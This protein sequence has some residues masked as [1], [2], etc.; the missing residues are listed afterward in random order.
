MERGAEEA[1][2]RLTPRPRHQALQDIGAGTA[3]DEYRE[4]IRRPWHGP[5]HAG[6][7]RPGHVERAWVRPRPGSGG[8]FDDHRR[9]FIGTTIAQSFFDSDQGGGGDESPSDGASP[10]SSEGTRSRIG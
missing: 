3:A 8:W 9:G 7:R 2:A 6:I 10:A 4:T 5:R 1:F